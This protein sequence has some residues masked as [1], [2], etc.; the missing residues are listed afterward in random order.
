MS[1]LFYLVQ[2]V[3][4]F[5]SLAQVLQHSSKMESTTYTFLSVIMNSA[6]NSCSLCSLYIQELLTFIAQR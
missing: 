4:P 3:L 1:K 2:T 6:R 5:H